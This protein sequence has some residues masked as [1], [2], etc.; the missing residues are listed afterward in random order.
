[1][2]IDLKSSLRFLHIDSTVK[3]DH[4]SEILFFSAIETDTDG[5][6]VADPAKMMFLAPSQ[7]RHFVH[8]GDWLKIW[9]FYREQDPDPVLSRLI[10]DEDSKQIYPTLGYKVDKYN[11]ET[12]T[13]DYV[14]EKIG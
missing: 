8:E 1:M 4:V 10:G 13:W 6:P 11:Y 14:Y 7:V 12:G 5:R 3:Y 2:T 9:D